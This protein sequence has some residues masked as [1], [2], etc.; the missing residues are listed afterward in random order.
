MIRALLFSLIGVSADQLTDYVTAPDANYNWFEESDKGFKTLW[1]NTARILNV[2]SQQWMDETK[3]QAPGGAIWTHTAIVVIPKKLTTKNIATV[4]LTG[5][6]NGDHQ[7]GLDKKSED[8]IVVDELAHN[9]GSIAVAVQQ[10]PNCPIVFPGDPLKKSRKEDAIMAMAW[11]SFI[12][13]PAHDISWIPRLPMVKAAF[14]VM[15]AV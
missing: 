2:T 8:V 5:N 15:R 1:G 7:G 6:C 14:Q 11:R 3:A 4:Y 9:T 12:D 13:D 10:I